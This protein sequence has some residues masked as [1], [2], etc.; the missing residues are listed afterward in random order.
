MNK[1][2]IKAIVR[3][4]INIVMKSSKTWVPIFVVTFLF[5][6][7]FPA[8][9]AYLGFRTEFISGETDGDIKKMTEKVMG[10]LSDGEMKNTLLELGSTGKMLSY[11]MLNFTFIS[12]FLMVAVINS[13]VTSSSSF[14]TEKERGTLETL[15]FSPISIR[16]LFIGKAMASF[17]PT[18]GITYVAYL[19]CVITVNAITY[20]AYSKLIMFNGMWFVMMFW[21]TPALILLVILFNVLVS[22]RSKTLQE[23]QQLGGIIILPAVGF[24]ISQTAG[25]FLLTGWIC[26]LIGLFL[27]GMVVLL[28]VL[29]AKYNNRNVLFESQIR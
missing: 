1:D 17:I 22:A 26:F 21:V 10:M 24:V 14:A 20:P 23:A 28:L 8:I 5:C 15:L 13:T 11:Y 2:M 7:L 16:D 9:L 18:L 27:F 25:L 12:L 3:K 19:V 29:T 4:D 6:V